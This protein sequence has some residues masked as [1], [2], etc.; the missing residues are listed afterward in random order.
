M[1][2]H[3]NWYV[4]AFAEE[5]TRVPLRRTLLDESVVLYR[6]STIPHPRF[7]PGAIPP[8]SAMT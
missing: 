2:L 5:V 7:A 4:A 6:T 3:D 1:Y 8:W